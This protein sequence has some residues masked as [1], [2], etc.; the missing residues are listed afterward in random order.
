MQ[1]PESV[2]VRE[3]HEILLDFK[4]QTDQPIPANG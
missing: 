4:K 3:S 2:E 1:K